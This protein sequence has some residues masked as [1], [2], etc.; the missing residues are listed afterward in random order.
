MSVI[1]IFTVAV[2][3]I[4]LRQFPAKILCDWESWN[5]IGQPLSRNVHCFASFIFQTIAK[6]SPRRG[7]FLC[8]AVFRKHEVKRWLISGQKRCR[9]RENQK[10]SYWRSL[11]HLVCQICSWSPR[12]GTSPYV[13]PSFHG[14]EITYWSKG[15]QMIAYKK[16]GVCFSF[17]AVAIRFLVLIR[18]FVSLLN[19][20]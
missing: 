15:Y 11:I 13:A 18:Q 10:I 6:T 3:F 12:C 7:L 4:F 17:S 14:E 8:P 9:R 1:K 2:L 19:F 16:V 20:V 5:V